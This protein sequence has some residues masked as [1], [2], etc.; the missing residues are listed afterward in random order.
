MAEAAHVS[1]CMCIPG[2]LG[3]V[4]AILQLGGG[5]QS[6]EV[7]E[8]CVE[9]SPRQAVAHRQLTAPHC[10]DECINGEATPPRA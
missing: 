4:L 3:S 2:F 8:D 7:V 5:G 1:W 9:S 10:Q 6:M